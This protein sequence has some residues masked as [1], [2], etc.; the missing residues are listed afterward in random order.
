VVQT[1]AS[2]MAQQAN[3]FLIYGMASPEVLNHQYRKHT[4]LMPPAHWACYRLVTGWRL[5][6]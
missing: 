5:T 3:R 4:M 2:E 6:R 1:A